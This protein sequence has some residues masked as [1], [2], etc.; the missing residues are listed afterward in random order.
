M[1]L[2]LVLAL[3]LPAALVRE[4]DGCSDGA[5]VCKHDGQRNPVAHR[6]ARLVNHRRVTHDRHRLD[7]SDR[8]ARLAQRHTRKMVARNELYHGASA[9]AVVG[10][11]SGV[12]AIVAAWMA[13]RPHRAVIL[14]NRLDRM[15]VGAVRTARVLWVTV[16]VRESRSIVSVP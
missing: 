7:W 13:S 11:G 5:Y 12:R 4:S 6:I 9:W 2:L 15:G 8:L 1:R 16:Q 3:V 14:N 10:V